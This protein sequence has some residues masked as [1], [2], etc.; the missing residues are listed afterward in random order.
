MVWLWSRLLA[1]IEIDFANQVNISYTKSVITDRQ[2]SE[3]HI[4][5]AIESSEALKNS[6]RVDCRE[7]I[8][9]Y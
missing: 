5:N 8:S 4:H 9:D 7:L 2:R 1:L 3:A 6:L